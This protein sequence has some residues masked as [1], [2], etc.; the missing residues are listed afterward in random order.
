MQRGGRAPRLLF[1]DRSTKLKTIYDLCTGARGGMV[2]SLF[3]VSDHLA[4]SGFDV[5]VLSDI[6]VG[7]ITNAGVE[8]INAET[9]WPSASK[10]YDVLIANRGVGSGY[11]AIDARRRVLWTHDLPH[12]GFIPNPQTIK[13]FDVTVFMSKYA[14]RVWRAFYKTI[15]RST[16][17]PNGVEKRDFYYDSYLK[18]E[19]YLIYASAPNRG[20]N[21]L[22][23]IFDALQSAL[24]TR[25]LRM[26]AYS[27]MSVLHPGEADYDI[28][29]KEFED[30]DVELL[31]PIPQRE[32]A[33][34]LREASL[35]VLP[36]NYPEICSN[37]ILQSL[38]CGTPIITTGNLGSAG[39]WV[40]HGRTGMLAEWMPAD[41]MIFWLEII[42]N[43]T[44]VLQRQKL[45]QSM[46]RR[47]AKVKIQSW[48]ETGA[49]WMNM[50]KRL[51]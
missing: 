21:K 51:L 27:S 34:Q 38:S 26:R 2:T 9:D 46:M 49:L 44:E 18:N 45:H 12:S 33:A 1:V 8:W 15:G 13:A 31:E 23:F 40:R 6:E 30:S 11:D 43:A 5:E 42:R 41:Y 22:P 29:Y 7:G 4:A 3:K 35:M 19:N 28:D 10:C 25:P 50:L 24:P 17:I 16:T 20:L 48:Q 37:T 14:E 36:S 39:E 32:F 47:A